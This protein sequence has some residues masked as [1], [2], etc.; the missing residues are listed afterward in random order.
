MTL[1]RGDSEG[2]VLSKES[3]VD[4]KVVKRPATTAGSAIKSF[5]FIIKW[6]ADGYAKR[7]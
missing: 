4:P 1:G 7:H 2:R 3:K 6:Y 5:H